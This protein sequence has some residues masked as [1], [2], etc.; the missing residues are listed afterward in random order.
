MV[1]F[2]SDTFE[3]FRK[4]VIVESEKQKTV[5]LQFSNLAHAVLAQRGHFQGLCAKKF[6][7]QRT[8]LGLGCDSK[9]GRLIVPESKKARFR[10][11]LTEIYKIQEEIDLFHLKIR[12]LQAEICS[13]R[14][15][16]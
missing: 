12:A 15:P 11:F 10:Q 4:E 16:D 3:H 9:H 2:F 13:S 7:L 14:A 8:I 5:E 1:S 6:E